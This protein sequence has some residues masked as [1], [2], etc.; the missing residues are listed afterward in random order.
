MAQ[1]NSK[2]PRPA[3]RTR[4]RQTALARASA[5]QQPLSLDLRLGELAA[6]LEHEPVEAVVGDEQVRAEP[7]RRHRQARARAPRRAPLQLLDRL[8]PRER[9]RRAPAPSVVKRESATPS[10]PSRELLEQQRPGAL[11]V[12]GADRQHEIARPR[13]AREEANRVLELGIQP[14]GMPGRSDASSSTTSVPS[15]PGHRLLARGVDLVTATASAA[16]RARPSS[17]ARYRVRE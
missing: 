2:P 6:E 5:G 13:A 4:C 14:I 16:A 9:P 8:R 1:A 10:R 7:D 17:C 15:T 3:A 11:D 12:A